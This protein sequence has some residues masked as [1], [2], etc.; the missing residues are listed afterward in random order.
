MIPFTNSFGEGAGI[1]A[2][3]AGWAA[4]RQA[5]V[6]QLK[7]YH[8]TN[9]CVLTAMG[10]IR[11]HVFIPAAYR[12]SRDAYADGPCPIGCGQTISQ[13][14]IVAYMTEKLALMPGNKVL[15]IGT[16]SG[17][18]AAVLAECGA[19]VYTI[20]IIPELAC[21]AHAAL[22][23]EGYQG[24]HILTGDGHKGWPEYSPF[25]A[26]IVTCAPDE[27]PRTLVDQL[28]EGG[29]LIAPVGRGS[30]RLVILHKQHGQVEQVEDLPVRFVPMV[31]E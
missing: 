7:V 9:T 10:K 17:Y 28:K 6:A 14:Y 22:D 4:R 16:G 5:M 3:D 31:R 15:E 11:R 27:V 29:H 20:E 25:D 24:I 12:N 19:D 1:S 18:Q 23:A 13:P 21:H 30:Q 8:I 26:I 2:E